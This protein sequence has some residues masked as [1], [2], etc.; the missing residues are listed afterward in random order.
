M[1]VKRM[2]NYMESR[3]ASGVGRTLWEGISLFR[4]LQKVRDLTRSPRAEDKNERENKEKEMQV[5][6]EGPQWC[7]GFVVKKFEK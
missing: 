2:H 7:G 6:D 4:F 5:K 3:N 1:T